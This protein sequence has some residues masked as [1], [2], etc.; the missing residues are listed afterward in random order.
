MTTSE[1]HS[2]IAAIRDTI[3][4]SYHELGQ[5]IDGP[6]GALEHARLY[7]PCAPDEWTLMENIV[8]VTEFMPYWGDEI[9][10]LVVHPGQN[11]GRTKEHEGRLQAIRQ[12]GH[13][14]LE[15]AKKDLASSY[16]RL[17]H[18]LDSLNDNDLALIGHHSKF[19][20]QNIEWFLDEFVV[21]H[22]ADHIEQMK[23]CL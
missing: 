13:D 17:E 1:S 21:R 19:G 14:S 12:H 6:I 10:K 4:R 3:Q 23:V 15:L 5:L 8:H 9:A 11:F 7:Q 22:L 16:A 2:R 18:V 20:D